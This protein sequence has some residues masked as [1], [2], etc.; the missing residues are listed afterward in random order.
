MTR[1]PSILRDREGETRGPGGHGF[2]EV[3]LEATVTFPVVPPTAPTGG[4]LGEDLAIT[5]DNDDRHTSIESSADHHRARW[6]RRHDPG[7][8]WLGT[9]G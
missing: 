3:D 7:A 1:T 8:R 9:W 2:D 4:V 6:L 5:T